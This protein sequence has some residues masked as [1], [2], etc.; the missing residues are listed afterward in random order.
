MSK[1]RSFVKARA[2]V[3]KCFICL[4]QEQDAE[5]IVACEMAVRLRGATRR[6]LAYAYLNLARAYGHQGRTEQSVN[7]LSRA[8]ALGVPSLIP[9][10]EDPKLAALRKHPAF[11]RALG[12]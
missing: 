11:V 8:V 5:A 4:L 10:E 2:Y 9:V 6:D 1:W 12:Q 3:R 7:A